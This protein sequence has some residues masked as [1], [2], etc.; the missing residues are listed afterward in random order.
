LETLAGRNA[1][2]L[3]HDFLDLGLG[4][5]LLALARRQD[6][7]GRTGFV[8]DVDG[9][10]G[11]VTVVDVLGA[12]FGRGLQGRHR[13]LHAMVLL[14]ARLQALEDVDGFLHGRLDHVDLLEATRQG[15]ILLEDAAVL[16]EG[17]RAD[18]LEL[19][20]GERRLEQVRCVQRA[21]RGR[22]R[23]DQRVDLVDE[24]HRVRLVLERLEHA[25]QALLEVAAVLGAG[26]QRAHVERVDLRFG[27]DL[28]HVALRDAPGQ[29]F[30]DRGL[31]HAGLAHQQRVVLAPAAQDLDDALDLVLAADQR[32][33]LA[34]LG[35]LVEVL[36]ELLERRCLLVLLA[37]A[38]LAF[39]EA[40]RFAALG[41]FRRI[42][43]LDAVG[44]EVDHVQAG[45]A[46][47]V[48]VVHGVRVLLAEDRDQHVG[49]GDFLLAVAGGLHVHDGAL[50]HALEPSVG[51]VSTSSVPATCGVLS[52]MKLVSDARRSST[53]AEH[54]RR[55]SAALGLSSKAS[56]RCS[57]VMNSWRCC[58]AST[59]AMCKLTSSSWAIM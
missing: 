33:D 35:Q 34:V 45:D 32:I 17:G 16:G 38:L 36:R 4:D 44:D 50:D 5:G 25:L 52:L 29:A 39:L 6:A 51:W 55:T 59:K 22:A 40:L 48:Q 18:A 10:V 11:Q 58:R 56:S 14:E 37:A 54:A 3:R 46:L 9:L 20:A 27:Q 30:R 26:Q 31:A 23:A 43:L 21:A 57:T 19:A 1:R 41:G 12:Q 15:R 8:D 53:L 13:V 49:A 7:L 24:Q 42:A 2:D 47:L 28:G